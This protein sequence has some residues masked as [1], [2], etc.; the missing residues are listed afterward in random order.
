MHTIDP[1]SFRPRKVFTPGYFDYSG[2]DDDSEEE[3]ESEKERGNH[4]NIA[5]QLQKIDGM[6]SSD[7]EAEAEEQMRESCFSDNDL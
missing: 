7:A 5:A 1:A 6:R 3:S 4:S 2:N